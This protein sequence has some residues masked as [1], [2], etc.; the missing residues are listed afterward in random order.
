MN[1]SFYDNVDDAVASLRQ[2]L[3]TYGLNGYIGFG[4][5]WCFYPMIEGTDIRRVLPTGVVVALN[6][7]SGIKVSIA[8]NFKV[9]DETTVPDNAKNL[10]LSKEV[11]N[12]LVSSLYDAYIR[13]CALFSNDTRPISQFWITFGSQ[14]RNLHINENYN[15]YKLSVG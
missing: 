4:N 13:L 8:E 2:V 1:K 5:T 9:I 15:I 3:N 12:M 10:V 7:G 11:Y 14:R 6:Q